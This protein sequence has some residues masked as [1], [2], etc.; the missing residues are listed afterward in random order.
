MVG[1]S[2]IHI[3]NIFGPH[4]VKKMPE[5]KIN[6]NLQKWLFQISQK[7]INAIWLSVFYVLM[8]KHR[9]RL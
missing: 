9:T 3:K 2:T 8:S 1:V 6:I 7:T 5:M 4:F